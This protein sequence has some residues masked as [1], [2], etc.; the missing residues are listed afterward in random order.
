LLQVLGKGLD[1]TCI[2][3]VLWDLTE[4]PPLW[5]RALNK[6]PDVVQW[7]TWGCAFLRNFGVPVQP[8]RKYPTEYLGHWI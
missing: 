2:K 5:A 6:M 8:E 1:Y 3:P 7:G 4:L